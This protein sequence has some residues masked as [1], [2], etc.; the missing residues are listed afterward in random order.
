MMDN[1]FEITAGALGG[2]GV[3]TFLARAYVSRAMK[4]L[5]HAISR[6]GEIQSQL[7]A[8]AV[9]LEALNK[10]HELI[11]ELDKKIIAIETKIHG[12]QNQSRFSSDTKTHL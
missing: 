1:P 9:R 6:V 4:D 7:A 5:E 2:L 11:H 3:G 10:T 8:I 12:R